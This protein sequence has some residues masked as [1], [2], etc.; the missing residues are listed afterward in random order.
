[1][2][3]DIKNDPTLSTSLVS[4][5]DFSGGNAND[6]HG[7]NNLSAVGS[8][9]FGSDGFGD[10]V[11]MT[12]TGNDYLDDGLNDYFEISGDRTYMLCVEF[13]SVAS[14]MELAYKWGAGDNH[15][16]YYNGEG[17]SLEFRTKN[18]SNTVTS[19]VAWN[20]LTGTKYWIGMKFDISAGEVKFFVNGS[21]QGTTQTGQNTTL[22][23]SSDDFIIGA[24][25]A[26]VNEFDGR[27][28]QYIVWDKYA[29]DTEFSDVY[30]SGALLPYDASA[31]G[32]G[33]GFPYAQAVIA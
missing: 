5:Y 6:V 27:I 20:P 25:A 24:N 18:N 9:T 32:G 14:Y 23:S 29:A 21:Q 19:S 1:M 12:L 8:P 7:T 16:F 33:G 13:D 4:V 3:T 30:N 22:D 11:G 17:K 10:Y 15:R 31:G 26:G 2:A 28:Y